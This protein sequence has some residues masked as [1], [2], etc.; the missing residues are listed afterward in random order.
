MANDE[1]VGTNA[2]SQNRDL[3][4][5]LLARSETSKMRGILRK[6][7]VLPHVVVRPPSETE[8]SDSHTPSLFDALS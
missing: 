4:P 3:E 2:D 7:E 5:L 6:E 8:Q 1:N